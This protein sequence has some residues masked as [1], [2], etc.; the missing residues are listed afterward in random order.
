MIPKIKYIEQT[1]LETLE[2]EFFRNYSHRWK[3][4]MFKC[5]HCYK[6]HRF[7]L[8]RIQRMVNVKGFKVFPLQSQFVWARGVALSSEHG[9]FGSALPIMH[10]V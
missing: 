2:E 6:P 9:T 3:K 8:W 1:A 5:F 7:P 4:A 10:W